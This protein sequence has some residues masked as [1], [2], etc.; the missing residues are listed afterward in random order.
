M[1]WVY[2]SLSMILFVVGGMRVVD[3]IWNARTGYTDVEAAWQAPLFLFL[4]AATLIRAVLLMRTR[5]QTRGFP[6]ES[7]R[8][9]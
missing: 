8:S 6:V 4:A 2:L 7:V 3:F 5:R 9:R 1:K